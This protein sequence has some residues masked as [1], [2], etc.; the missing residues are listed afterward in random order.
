MATNTS[1]ELPQIVEFFKVLGEKDEIR[2]ELEASIEAHEQQLAAQRQ[3]AQELRAE[4]EA[5]LA[6]ITELASR[7]EDLCAVVPSRAQE[8]ET[9]LGEVRREVMAEQEQLRRIQ[10][11]QRTLKE[12]I[13]DSETTLRELKAQ[14]MGAQDMARARTFA[15]PIPSP[16][17]ATI[18]N[19]DHVRVQ[20]AT[21]DETAEEASA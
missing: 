6:V 21:A 2:K 7:L 19:Q 4:R 20:E 12:Q 11:Y 10:T 14:I 17:M 18:I 16:H 3:E 8:L 15:P 1:K 9:R 13:S 5:L